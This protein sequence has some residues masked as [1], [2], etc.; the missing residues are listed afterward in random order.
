MAGHYFS[1]RPEAPER[2][3]LLR[4]WLRGLDFEFVTSSGVFSPRALDRGTRLLVESMVL[5]ESGAVL[6]MG[7]GYG[8]VGIAAARLRPWL[9]VW[10]TDVNERAVALAEENAVRNV[11][12][13]VVRLGD[14]YE[15]VGDAVF[16]AIL[17]NP[18]ISAGMRRV[19]EP[20]VGG[21][22]DRLL[23]GGSLQLVV[24]SNKGGRAVASLMEGHFGGVEVVARGGG[25]RVLMSVKG[26]VLG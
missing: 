8:P 21:A 9:E 5:P 13:V 24:Q 25:Y 18:P 4:C 3:G 12:G 2:R 14:L 1:R 17:S 6:D 19:V 26:R 23:G 16:G 10:M 20:L 7:C 11:V 15:P 22:V